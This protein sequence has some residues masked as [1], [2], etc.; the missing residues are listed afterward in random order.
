MKVPRVKRSADGDRLEDQKPVFDAHRTM[1]ALQKRFVLEALPMSRTIE[2]RDE[3]GVVFTVNSNDTEIAFMLRS[4]LIEYH[5][6]KA[7][8]RFEGGK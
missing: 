6:L 5:L 4:A 1:L 3:F 2:C 8:A 7:E